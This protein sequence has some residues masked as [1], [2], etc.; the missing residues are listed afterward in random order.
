M[1]RYLLLLTLLFTVT[2]CSSSQPA[3]T[4]DRTPLPDRSYD[5]EVIRSSD[6]EAVDSLDAPPRP[7]EGM[8]RALRLRYPDAVREAGLQP[9]IVVSFIVGSD[10]MPYDVD[11]ER[12]LS[13]EEIAALNEEARDAL[14]DM[15]HEAKSLVWSMEFSPAT[16]DGEPVAVA[17]T[18]PVSFQIP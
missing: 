17:M 6:E 15:E 9:R 18:W 11:V 1:R 12:E 8:I 13:D 16:I 3:T 7:A 14:K 4:Y 2:A 5:G 10:G